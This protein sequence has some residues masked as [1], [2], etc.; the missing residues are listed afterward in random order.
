MRAK[1][2]S[3]I[4]LTHLWFTVLMVQVTSSKQNWPNDNLI[5]SKLQNATETKISKKYSSISSRFLTSD[6]NVE[7]NENV[8][9][10]QVKLK[11]LSTKNSFPDC[12][13][14]SPQLLGPLKVI[15][16]FK[17]HLPDS[18][19]FQNW[20]GENLKFGGIYQPPNCVAKQKVAIIVPFR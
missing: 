20:F 3:L 17:E 10:K 15:E 8:T 1:S 19:E 4:T 13:E 6:K 16:D 5:N 18:K 7:K 9:S 14:K 12:P 2:G 11:D